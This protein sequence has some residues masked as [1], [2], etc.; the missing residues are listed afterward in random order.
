MKEVFIVSTA[1]TPI[2]S[3]GGVFATM[4]AVQLGSIA[5]KGAVERAGIDPTQVE[6]V[7]F[8]NVVAANLGQAPATQ[9]AIGAGLSNRTPCTTVNKVCASGTKS[10]MFGA[11]QI[12]LGLADLVVTGGTESMTNI[13]FYLDKARFGYGYGNGQLI[14]GLAKDGLVD[15]Y[16][17]MAMG[18]CSDATAAKY[19]ITREQQDAFAISSYKKSAEATSTGYL[20]KEIVPVSVPQKKG[21]AVLVTEDEEF[22]KVNFDKI[23]TLKPVF[24]KEGTTTAANAST[25]NDGAVALVLASGEMVKKLNLK[26]LARIVSFADAAHAPEWFTTAPVLAAPIALKRAGLSIHDMDTFEVNEAFATVVLAFIQELGIDPS[27]V[28]SFGGAISLGHPLGASGARIIGAAAN[29]LHTKGGRYG[30][31][32][33]CNGGGGAAAMVIEKV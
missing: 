31:I 14:D 2:G 9:V 18:V 19:G 33:I 27:K 10:T 23:P 1:R 28:N 25:M 24:T 16:G 17:N 21:D 3:Y 26:P 4:S 8:G 29:V 6:E 15:A 13:P 12:Q 32:A 7:F 30:L 22:K 5:V 20:S 11:M